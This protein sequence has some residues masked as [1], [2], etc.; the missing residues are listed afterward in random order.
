MELRCRSRGSVA[1]NFGQSTNLDHIS[2]AFSVTRVSSNCEC[3]VLLG[4]AAD[5]CRTV[6]ER[7]DAASVNFAGK[8]TRGRDEEMWSYGVVIVVIVIAASLKLLL[9]YYLRSRRVH[10]SLTFFFFLIG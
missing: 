10:F 4:I 8:P 9:R 5:C 1:C 2:Q 7:L 6:M 3:A